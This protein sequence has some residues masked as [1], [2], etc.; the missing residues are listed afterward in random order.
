M[1]HKSFTVD[2]AKARMES[3]CAYQ[4]RCHQEVRNRLYQMRIIPEAIDHIITHL[5]EHNYLN[6]TRFAQA[7][8]RGKFRTKS[9]GKNRIISELKRRDIS[10]YTITIALKEIP[11]E[12]YRQ[13]F[14]ELTQKRLNQLSGEKDL[15]KK[16]RKLADYLFYRGWEPELVYEK[17]NEIQ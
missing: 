16:R 14:E 11:E 17:I 6:E 10:S 7:F 13:S 12:D 8:A 9:W 4:E 5:I 2:E 3:Y 1:T 15:Q